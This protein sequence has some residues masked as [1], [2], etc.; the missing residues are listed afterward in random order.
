MGPP[1]PVNNAIYTQL[2]E[3]WYNAQD[4]PVALLRAE[5]R[6]RTGWIAER[7][8]QAFAHGCRVLDVGC[9]AG[10]VANVLA[11]A[12]HRICGLDAAVES[13][14]VARRHDR[15][16]RVQW[17]L[18]DATALPF[19]E[20]SFDAVGLMDV[21]EHIEAPAAAI[22][23]AARLLVPGGLLFF[24]TY[25]RNWLTW[26][27]VVKGVEWIVRNTPRDVHVHRLLIEPAELTAMCEEAGL[28]VVELVG[29]RPRIDGAMLRL[30]LTGVVPDDFRFT[31][32]RS[33]RL[34]YAGVARR[35]ADR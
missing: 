22:G 17:Q 27:V 6:L 9:G 23:A 20:R 11:A 24:T 32:T 33:T 8:R 31:F 7:L 25:S 26:L 34:G 29:T 5:A 10:F 16:R 4:D 18:G 1:R 28:E 13:L 15:T 21:L 14:T 3:R 35:R 12:G 30:L 2:G 19:R